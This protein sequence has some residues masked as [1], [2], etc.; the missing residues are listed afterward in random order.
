MLL[1]AELRKNPGGMDSFRNNNPRVLVFS[2]TNPNKA[3]N[4]A[5]STLVTVDFLK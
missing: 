1:D 4:K 2:P 3:L 5:T